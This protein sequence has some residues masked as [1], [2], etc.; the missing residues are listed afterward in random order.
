MRA[1]R[2]MRASSRVVRE[3]STVRMPLTTISGRWASNFLEVH[4][5]TATTTMFAGSMPVFSA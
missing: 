4:G 1:S 3:T 2:I 5:I